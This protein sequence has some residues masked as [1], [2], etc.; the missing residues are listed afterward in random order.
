MTLLAMSAAPCTNQNDLQTLYHSITHRLLS[1]PGET[2]IYPGLESK[3]RRLISIEELRRKDHWFNNRRGEGAF[4]HSCA[5]LLPE[6][7]P[8]EVTRK[9]DMSEIGAQEE[10]VH[11]YMPGRNIPTFL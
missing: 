6:K 3:G 7:T 8:V 1:F 4:L 11:Y 2:L 9:S 10:N 5:L